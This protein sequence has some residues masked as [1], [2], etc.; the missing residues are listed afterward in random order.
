VIG[1]LMERHYVTP[2]ESPSNGVVHFLLRELRTPEVLI[3]A[4]ARFP[5]VARDIAPHRPVVQ[6]ALNGDRES[7]FPALRAERDEARG[8]DRIWWEPLKRELEPPLAT[9]CV[10]VRVC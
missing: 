10:S 1:L 8:L 5:E 2:G 9:G 6:A 4:V 7:L 3:E